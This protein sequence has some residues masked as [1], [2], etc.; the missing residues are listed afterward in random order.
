MPTVTLHIDSFH[1]AAVMVATDTDTDFSDD[2]LT[3]EDAAEF[4]QNHGNNARVLAAAL[5]AAEYNATEDGPVV[6]IATAT[7]AGFEVTDHSI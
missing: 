6:F 3:A 7:A 4:A 5:L 1:E 2:L